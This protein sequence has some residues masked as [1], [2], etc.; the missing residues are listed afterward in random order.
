M[1]ICC[2]FTGFFLGMVIPT[3]GFSWRFPPVALPVG[4]HFQSGFPVQTQTVVCTVS[5][6]G[7]QLRSDGSDVVLPP[8]VRQ[9]FP[10]NFR[11]SEGIA[12]YLASA[13]PFV[14]WPDLGSLPASGTG[15]AFSLMHAAV[16]TF[17]RAGC[18]CT[19]S[20][21]LLI[22]LSSLLSEHP[23]AFFKVFYISLKRGSREISDPEC[24]S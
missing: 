14:H 6:I 15:W 2:V 24:S 5:V 22:R 9:K 20:G 16:R 17:S 21:K 23:I 3:L 8:R 7:A 10:F 4:F 18:Q 19:G 13:I 12:G 11:V 1:Q